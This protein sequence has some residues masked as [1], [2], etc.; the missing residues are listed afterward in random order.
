VS[1]RAR[2][3][4][5]QT[6]DDPPG[7]ED[8]RIPRN[9]SAALQRIA[10]E[11][12]LHSRAPEEAIATVRAFFDEHFRYT[13]FL[14]LP[15]ELSV[16]EASPLSRFLLDS[17]EGHCEYFASATVL[18]L[19]EAGIPARYVTGYAVQEFS[20]REER[21]VV[22]LR[23]AHAWTLYYAAGR[24]HELDTTP[25]SWQEVESA[26]AALWEP[27]AD[28]LSTLRFRFA[29]WRAE[30]GMGALVSYGGALLVPLIVFGAWRFLVKKRRKRFQRRTPPGKSPVRPHGIDSDFY[31]L[32][33]QLIRC[34]PERRP[35]E[36]PARWLAR[37]SDTP[38]CRPLASTLFEAIRLHYRHRFDPLGL[39]SH[40]RVKLARMVDLCIEQLRKAAHPRR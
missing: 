26:Q 36:S 12:A 33:G 7:I 22:R 17:R 8:L 6:I 30:H 40:E 35:G 10:K 37:I 16:E 32:E 25:G 19:R 39:D 21:Y 11:L 18:L 34:A 13:T 28:Y 27:M 14:S 4:P 20:P 2:F 9:E 5:G 24:W 23:D 15:S 38:V 1:Y 31:R 3:H 29:R